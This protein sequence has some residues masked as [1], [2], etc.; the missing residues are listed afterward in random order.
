VNTGEQKTKT[1]LSQLF[2]LL[3]DGHRKDIIWLPSVIKDT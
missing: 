2:D 1:I 3:Y